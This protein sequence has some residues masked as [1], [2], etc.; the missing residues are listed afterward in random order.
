MAEVK[1]ETYRKQVHPENRPNQE[2]GEEEQSQLKMLEEL[3]LTAQLRIVTRDRSAEEASFFYPELS[4]ENLQI[5]SEFLPSSYVWI[6]DRGTTRRRQHPEGILSWY[7]GNRGMV[8]TQEWDRYSYDSIPFLALKDIHE[9]KKVNCFDYLTIRT[10][11]QPHQIDPAVIGFCGDRAFLVTRWG[12]S[13]QPFERI[14]EVVEERRR[15]REKAAS[16]RSL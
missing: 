2:I 12:E 7:P 11:E 1:V 6:R 8:S 10:P 9:A 14:K 13:L 5:W 4:E 15:D 16:G 3:G